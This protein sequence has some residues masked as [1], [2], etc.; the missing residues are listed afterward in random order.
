MRITSKIYCIILLWFVFLMLLLL[1]GSLNK[2]T[3]TRDS[4][5]VLYI[6][7]QILDGK[8]P[9]RD[10]WEHKPPLLWYINS[11]G[12]VLSERPLLWGIW[13]I[14]A[15]FIVSSTLLS[16]MILKNSFGRTPAI[17]GTTTW[18]IALSQLLQGGNTVEEYNL[19]LQFTLLLLFC[20]AETHR[21]IWP[22]HLIGV[23]S[24]LSFLLKPNLV[25]VLFAIFVYL[26]LQKVF[27]I[28]WRNLIFRFS[29]I[30]LGITI[31]GLP[32]VLYLLFN[33]IISE[34][35]DQVFIY[36]SVYT[37][38]SLQNKLG[39][40]LMAF[41]RFPVLSIIS[42]LGFVIGIIF[43]SLKIKWNSNKFI[44]TKLGVLLFPIE[45]VLASLSG[46]TYNH[47]YIAILPSV[48]ILLAQLGFLILQSLR[49]LRRQF[50][51]GLP[52]L[53]ILLVLLNYNQFFVLVNRNLEQKLIGKKLSPRSFY[54]NNFEEHQET[55]RFIKENTI[56]SDYV[57]VW[58]SE[59]TIN[60]VT[61]RSSPSRYFHQ[62][63]LFTPNYYNLER[64]L[65]FTHEIKTK[66][67]KIIIDASTSTIDQEVG[68]VA[69]VPPINPV[70]RT[71]WLLDRGYRFDGMDTFFD[72]VQ[73]NY[74]YIGSL[75]LG[76]WD[77]YRL[78]IP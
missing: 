45:I 47:Y 1:N 70:K 25:G 11:V 59:A 53:F 60:F 55:I 27:V 57:L 38:V 65:E 63:A 67:P 74:G 75:E 15:I 76:K 32:I 18:L 10:T 7:N 44:L 37:N 72:E 9:Y 51:L 40:S 4:G 13:F 71:V 69:I 33:G 36:N 42:F 58:G 73:N 64:F 17:F 56:P 26:I 2:G 31:V 21:E 62:Y 28:G 22:Y 29:A 30:L 52:L 78:K 34:F 14:E 66:K 5:I 46:R 49:N 77:I 54:F 6:G 41:K 61:Q 39:L 35:I 23:L 43:I 3:P 12:I 8:I 24:G 50:N 48:S 16:Y 68:T 19:L 20:R